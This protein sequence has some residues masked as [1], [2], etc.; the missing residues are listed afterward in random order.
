MKYPELA[1]MFLNTNGNVRIMFIKL[2][3]KQKL[4]GLWIKK[5]QAETHSLRLDECVYK[6]NSHICV[7]VTRNE[8]STK[9]STVQKS[10]QEKSHGLKW[11][12][13]F[14]VTLYLVEKYPKI[15]NI[16]ENECVRVFLFV[17]LSLSRLVF[18]V[19]VCSQFHHYYLR[20]KKKPV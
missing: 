12:F 17:W 19:C 7:Y 8:A 18:F 6:Q 14:M 13:Q 15:R 5:K 16:N 9:M 4:L 3:Q 10:K 11:N 1:I 20:L 2:R